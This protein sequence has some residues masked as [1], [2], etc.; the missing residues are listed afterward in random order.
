MKSKISNFGELTLYS[1]TCSD[2]SN[3]LPHQLHCLMMD[4]LMTHTDL[5][6]DGW[7]H[8]LNCPMM[9]C[10]STHTDLSNDGAAAQEAFVRAHGDLHLPRVQLGVRDHP[11]ELLVVFRLAA[12]FYNL[13]QILHHNYNHPISTL[14]I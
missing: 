3:G 10:P 6:K 7:P 12:I 13:E 11:L 14:Y 9:V 8:Q 5:S 2:Q 1:S 4:F